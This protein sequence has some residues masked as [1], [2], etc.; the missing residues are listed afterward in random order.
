[1]NTLQGN[2]LQ[3][4]ALQREYVTNCVLFVKVSLQVPQ[5]SHL[6]NLNNDL[7]DYLQSTD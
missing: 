2:T 5:Y 3:E 4:N 7:E 6:Y 1:M